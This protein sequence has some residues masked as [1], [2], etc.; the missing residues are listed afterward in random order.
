MQDGTQFGNLPLRYLGRQ[1]RLR[2]VERPAPLMGLD[3]H[4]SLHQPLCVDDRFI[5]VQI[6][7]AGRAESGI[8]G[9]CDTIRTAS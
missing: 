6:E 2:S 4:A 8:K 9:V 3:R 5:A 7:L 1:H